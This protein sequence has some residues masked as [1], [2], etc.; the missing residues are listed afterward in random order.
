MEEA[1]LRGSD[2][3]ETACKATRAAPLRQPARAARRGAAG[4]AQRVARD[5]ITGERPGTRRRAGGSG[6]A[7]GGAGGA[8]T[9][10]PARPVLMTLTFRTRTGGHPCDTAF[11]CDGCPFPSLNDPPTK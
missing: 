2:R 7:R 6:G 10:Y 8:E 9:G 4:T 3:R 5:T 1:R 11:D